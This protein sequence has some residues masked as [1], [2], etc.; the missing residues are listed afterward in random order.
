M[1][2]LRDQLVEAED[3]AAELR[4]R[5]AAE[6]CAT[7]GH[8]W[9]HIGG[10]NAACSDDCG[11]SVPVHE[12]TVCGDSDYG[13]NPEA[14][15]TL[16]ECETARTAEKLAR[17]DEFTPG[18]RELVHPNGAPMFNPDSGTMLDDAGNRSIFDDVDE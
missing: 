15:K 8:V 4:R 17:L 13:D 7:A 5:I 10:R 9:R 18:W 2:T 6:G 16:A 12:C 11:C 1:T 3:R 14:A